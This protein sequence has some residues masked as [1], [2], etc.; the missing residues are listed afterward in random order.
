[1]RNSLQPKMVL[2]ENVAE[3]K[4][5]FKK[6]YTRQIIE[7][8][9]GLGY[10][11]GIEKLLAADYG[12]PQLRRRTFFFANQI[13]APIKF[14]CPTHL[15]PGKNLNLFETERS[16]SYVTVWEAIADLSS[17]ESEAGKSPCDYLQKPETSYQHQMRKNSLLLYDRITRALTAPQLERVLYLEPGKGKVWKLYRRIFARVVATVAR[18]RDSFRMNLPERLPDGFFTPVRID[19]IITFDNRMIT[20]REAA[21]LQS[22][23]DRFTFAGSYIHKSHQVGEAVPPLLAQAFAKE[24]IAALSP[25]RSLQYINQV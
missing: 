5:A 13:K 19:F 9:N 1:M 4:N 23:P 6:A 22:F 24:A 2:I 7:Q 3:M 14:P 15:A 20:I 21:R 17:L 12:V 18:M 16:Q 8:L 25:Q 11:V 10:Y